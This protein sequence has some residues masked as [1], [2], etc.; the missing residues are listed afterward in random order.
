MAVKSVRQHTHIHTNSSQ[1]NSRVQQEVYK[2]VG[3]LAN[4]LLLPKINRMVTI[5]FLFIM[6]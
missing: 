5:F 1:R 6:E 4:M 2:M 3:R